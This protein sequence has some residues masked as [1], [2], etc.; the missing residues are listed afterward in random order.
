[1]AFFSMKFCPHCLGQNAW[2]DALAAKRVVGHKP[3]D[4]WEVALM[5]RGCS[6]IIGLRVKCIPNPTEYEGDIA[7]SGMRLL[8]FYPKP[9]VSSPPDH[10]PEDVA[11]AYMQAEAN[12][13]LKLWDAAAT[14]YRKALDKSTVPLGE[15]KGRLIDRIDALGKAG[16]ITPSIHQWAH[17]IRIDG[18]EGAHGEADESMAQDIKA[19]TDAFLTYVFT[20]PGMIAK[21]QEDRGKDL[22]VHALPPDTTTAD[23]SS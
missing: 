13:K 11:R 17:V 16:T 12:Q 4:K 1:M 6:K 18:N 8:A 20:V 9:D 19:F 5:C 22:S 23:T 10:T 2:A 21:W 3:G 7:D 14:M 15:A